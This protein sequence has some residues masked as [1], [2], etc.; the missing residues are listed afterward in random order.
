MALSY[1][2]SIGSVRARENA[3]FNKTDIEQL[4]GCRT[5][6][7][8]C[9]TL[10]DKGYGSVADF[11][12]RLGRHTAAVWAYL[13]SVAPDFAVFTPFLIQNDIHNFK[14]VLK[15]IMSAR[16]Y[17]KALLISPSTLEHAVVIDAIE[18]RN[19]SA[20]P[21]WL[22]QPAA[23]AY[24]QLA[25]SGDA[26]ASDAVLDKALMKEMLRFAQG[27]RSAFLKEYINTTVFYNNVKIALRA[28]RTGADKN[29][30]KA[31]LVKTEGFDRDSV[32]AAAVKG[33]EALKTLLQKTTAY[34]CRQAMEAFK[35]SPSD[36]EKF[37]DDRLMAL[38]R[39]SCKRASE[40]AEPLLGYYLGTEAEK[41]VLHIIFSGIKTGT[42]RDIIRERLRA[43]YG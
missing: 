2:F 23:K 16:D 14:V 32:I 36:F 28:A 11:D 12:K 3:L 19:M 40:G 41:K 25:H 38:A 9:Q 17:Y 18:H 22:Q 26:K 21:E 24:D 37:V 42:D 27:F 13:K 35:T 31:A 7:E 4:L 39:E 10:S 20:L 6:A 1:E 43:I 29:Y 33:S 34:G 30:L 8:L 5:E 15:G